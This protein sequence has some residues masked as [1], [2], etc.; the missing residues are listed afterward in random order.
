MSRASVAGSPY[1]IVPSAAVGT[2]LTNYTITYVDGELTVSEPP[3]PV[4]TNAMS[5]P[6][7]G[8]QFDLTTTP[9]ANYTV[10]FNPDLAGILRDGCAFADHQVQL[11][12][13]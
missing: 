1:A 9:G 5:L 7:G 2:G 10:Q 3:A 12:I 11:E 4:L 6:G 13:W 8:I